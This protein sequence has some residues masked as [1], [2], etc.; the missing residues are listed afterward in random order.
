MSVQTRLLPAMRRQVCC[1]C[2]MQQQP[3]AS[4]SARTFAS[5]ASPAAKLIERK[6]EK[7]DP[8]DMQNLEEFKFDDIPWRGHLTLE[9]DR[10]RLHLLRL[11]EFQLPKIHSGSLA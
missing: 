8:M 2:R 4:T 11:I 5:S 6:L 1:A 9:K 3:A 10:E 7:D